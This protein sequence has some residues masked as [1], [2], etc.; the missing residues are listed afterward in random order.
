MDTNNLANVIQAKEYTLQEILNGKKYTVDYFQREYSW[1]KENIEQLIYDLTTA[2]F[3]EYRSTHIIQN[4]AN[5]NTYFMGSLVLSDKNGNSSIIDGQQRITSLTLLLIYLYHATDKSMSSQLESLIYSDSYGSKSFNIQVPE[6][7]ECLRA[8]FDEGTYTVK[9]G[10]DEST[11]NMALMFEGIGECFPSEQFSNPDTLKAFVYWVIGKVILVKITAMSENNAYTIFETMNNRGV[12]LT[13]SD[14]LKGFILSKFSNDAKRKTVNES[15]KKDMQKLY[16]YGNDTEAQFF[17]SWLRSQFADSIRQTKV[18]SLNMDFENIGTRFHNWFKENYDKGLLAVAID[19]D[20]ENFVDKNYK[21]YLGVYIKIRKAEEA[22]QK[23]LEHIYYIKRWGIAASLSYP[24]LLAPICSDDSP[25]IINEK[26]EIVAKY[27]DS[28]VVYRS[29]NFRNFSASSI[30]YTMYSLVKVIR[31]K[32]VEELRE[33]LR[34]N[35]L[36]IESQL[37]FKNAMPNFKMHGMNKYFIKYFLS[38]ITSYVEEGSGLGIHFE[39]YMHNP[40]CK[41]FEIEHIWCDKYPLFTDE[42][43]QQNDFNNW[44]NTIGDL[45]LLQRGTNQ[46]YSDKIYTDKM[47]H[48]LKENLLAMSLCQ[49]AYQNNPNFTNFIH[50]KNLSFKEHSQYKKQDIID[51]CNLYAEI[52]DQI[53]GVDTL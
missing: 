17:Q 41:P 4:V 25:E 45:I 29:T 23:D 22:F 34:N 19:G 9:E 21:F 31:N 18:G 15:W 49:G 51:R 12:S 42:F 32:S 26:L 36:E 14:M 44:R 28:F 50:Q 40:N 13:S 27:I 10:A 3:D 46:S 7:E 53:W 47:P 43:T 30:R 33:M 8:L 6:R 20:I 1:K 24:L 11:R 37:N 52:A 35:L 5:Y 16:V 39:K 38:R 48:Y 2:F